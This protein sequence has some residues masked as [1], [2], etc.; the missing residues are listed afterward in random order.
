MAPT[1]DLARSLLF[2]PGKRPERFE[3]LDCVRAAVAGARLL[4]MIETAAGLDAVKVL[5]A[6]DV[7]VVMQARQTVARALGPQAS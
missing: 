5:A 6:V 2:V 7:P 1:L 4:P 3:T